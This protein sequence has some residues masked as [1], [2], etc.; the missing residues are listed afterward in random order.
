MN[1][2]IV[3]TESSI[4]LGVFLVVFVV[5]AGAEILFPRRKLDYP[6]FQRWLSN[7]ALSAV[8]TGLLRL[9]FPIA[10]VGASLLATEQQWGLLNQF[11]APAWLSIVIFLLVFDL[12][13]YWQ[14]RLFHAVPLLWRFHRI[15]HMDVD[16]DLTTGSRFH[17][18]SIFM[19]AAIKLALVV[20]MG[21]PVAAILFAEVLLNITSMFNHSNLKLPLALD[22]VLRRVIVTPDMHRIHHSTDGVEHSHNYGFNFSCWDRWFGSYLPLAKSPQETMSIGIEGLQDR[23]SIN[24][25]FILMQPF[26]KLNDD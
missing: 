25:F 20:V 14:H 16:Y 21:A 10:G 5:L 23:R 11:S 19:S 6:K 15:H 4:R 2:L 17:P 18:V 13:I 12:T 7:L 22:G 1:N 9:L 3:D 8:N 26:R 24:L